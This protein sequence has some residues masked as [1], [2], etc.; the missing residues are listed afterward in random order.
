[1]SKWVTAAAFAQ[2]ELAKGISP[3]VSGCTVKATIES[4]LTGGAFRLVFAEDYGSTAAEYISAV[5]EVA[6]RKV[7]LTFG[8]AKAFAV[9][10]G[11]RMVS[12]PVKMPVGSG[13]TVTLWLAVGAHASASETAIEQQHTGRG[14]YS[15]DGFQAE[16]YKCPLPG[17]PFT[18]RLCGLKE[19]QVEVK[20]AADTGS[21]AVFG[22][23][24][25]ESAVWIKPLQKRIR[26]ENRTITLLNLG[27]GGNRLLKNT[28]VPMMMGINAFGNAG[29]DRLEGDVLA[30]EGVKGVIVAMGINDIAQP[31]GAPG[32]SPPLHELCTAEELKAGL[33][34]V[35]KRCRAKGLAVIGATITPFK[36]YSSYNEVTA[37]IRTEVNEWILSCGLFDMVIDLGKLL[38]SPEDPEAIPENWQIG[39]HLHPNPI[40]G[41][42]AAEQ[43][44]VKRLLG[45]LADGTIKF[46]RGEMLC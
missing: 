7:R 5:A 1:M 17:A 2:R 44:D 11:Q 21:I 9:N 14:D 23:S 38:G 40:G 28:N 16:P 27:I 26:D 34:E 20:E 35:V 4:G 10:P 45:I 25:A 33:A 42:A 41:A 8:G 32:F 3:D 37:D 30:L 13:E 43:V 6:G 31:G 15:Q 39:D 24:I 12:D 22:D 29:L 36:G 18:E 19:L 46:Q